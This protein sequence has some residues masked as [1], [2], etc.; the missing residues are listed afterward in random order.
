MI[1][2]LPKRLTMAAAAAA[3]TLKLTFDSPLPPQPELPLRC[4]HQIQA[5]QRLHR[6]AM[7][8]RRRRRRDCQRRS[9]SDIL[10]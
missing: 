9:K 5:G 3:G 4:L 2:R 10:R 7:L 1:R 6:G 8:A